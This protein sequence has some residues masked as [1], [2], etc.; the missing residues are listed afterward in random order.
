MVHAVE[1]L[2]APTCISHVHVAFAVEREAAGRP[3]L[4][5]RQERTVRREAV[6]RPGVEIRHVDAVICR[7]GQGGRLRDLLDIQLTPPGPSELSRLSD[8]DD[9]AV[10]LVR[11]VD[12]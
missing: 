3:C 4:P 7:E 1:K 10:A 6:D 11:D 9:E 12:A 8:S 2:R 5:T